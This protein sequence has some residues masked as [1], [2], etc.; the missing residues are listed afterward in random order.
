MATSIGK[1]SKSFFVKLLV[2]III[3]PFVFWGMG[4]VFR[5]GNQ[6]TIVKIDNEKVSTKDF[7]EYLENY[8]NPNEEL[9]EIENDEF[10]LDDWDMEDK[11]YH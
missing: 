6:N 7:V 11:I 9:N 1:L 4:D 10:D 8:T 2:G 3:L 5:S